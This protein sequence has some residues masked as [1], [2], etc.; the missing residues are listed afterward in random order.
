MQYAPSVYL[1]SPTT[2][3][4]SNNQGLL[5]ERGNEIFLQYRQKSGPVSQE[6]ERPC[7][8]IQGKCLHVS[9]FKAREEFKEP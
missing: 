3:V 2:C 6:L 5:V 1:L 9:H 4:S 7:C 8:K